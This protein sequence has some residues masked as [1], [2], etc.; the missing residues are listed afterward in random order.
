M[1]QLL[2]L[3]I[4]RRQSPFPIDVLKVQ[5]RTTRLAVQL[6]G[7]V[8]NTPDSSLVDTLACTFIRARPTFPI[9]TWDSHTATKRLLTNLFDLLES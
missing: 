4:S 2:A 3:A 5:E 7:A 9:R 8:P 6:A 1:L